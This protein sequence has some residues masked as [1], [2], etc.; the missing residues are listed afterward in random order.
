MEQET[1]LL[2]IENEIY[3]EPASTGQR[4][5]NYLIDIIIFYVVLFAIGTAIGLGYVASETTL[6]SRGTS[7]TGS[8][9]TDYV[10][11]YAIYIFC[12]TLFEGASKGR[13]VGKWIT[14]TK[15]VAENGADINWGDAFKRSLSRIV[16]FEPLSAFGGHPWHDRWT[17][18]KVIKVRK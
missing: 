1:S 18:T 13:T 17:H 11:I 9:F 15:A 4:F 16:P 10:L 12:Y 2:E 6:D 14:G 8:G 7:L 5:A 3:A